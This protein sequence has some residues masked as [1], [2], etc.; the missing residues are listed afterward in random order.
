MKTNVHNGLST[1]AV[2]LQHIYCQKSQ[3]DGLPLGHHYLS[4]VQGRIV[5]VSMFDLIP[6]LLGIKSRF[7]VVDGRCVLT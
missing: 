7:V 6:V 4:N 1:D 5:R 2:N 3:Y